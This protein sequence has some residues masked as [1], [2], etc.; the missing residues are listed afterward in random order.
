MAAGL[1]GGIAGT[2]A[3]KNRWRIT[4]NCQKE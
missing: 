2:Q 1:A 3:G 4:S